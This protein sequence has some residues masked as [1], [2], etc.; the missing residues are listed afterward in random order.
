MEVILKKD[1][2]NIGKAGAVVK[3]KDGFARNFLIPRGLGMPVTTQGLKVLEEEEQQRLL[4]SEKTRKEAEELGAKLKSI[5]LTMPV[6]TQADEKLYG[7]IGPVEIS[8]A[9][10]DEGFD[11]DKNRILLDDPIKALG[12]YEVLVKLHPDIAI[13]LKIW[14]V[15]K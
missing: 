5:S 7:S 11:I 4:L 8:A 3:V 13:K 14:V 12:I 1:V 9:L 6:L 2:N 10:K 15:K